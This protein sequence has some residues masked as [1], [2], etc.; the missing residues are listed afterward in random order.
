MTYDSSG[1][2]NITGRMTL[3]AE[4]L[5]PVVGHSN[6]L[7]GMSPRAN[8]TDRSRGTGS[9]PGATRFSEK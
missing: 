4:I 1:T 9:I 5:I 6:K 7:P 8:Y 2:R 3:F